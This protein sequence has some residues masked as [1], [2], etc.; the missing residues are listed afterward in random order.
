MDM[1]KS[2][3]G[4][5]SS[6]HSK[7]DGMSCEMIGKSSVHAL[8]QL[9]QAKPGYCRVF[10]FIVLVALVCGCV[11]EVNS[12]FSIFFQYPVLID[13]KVQNRK[14]LEFPAVTLCNLNRIQSYYVREL[15]RL[16]VE[17]E[18]CFLSEH[19][20]CFLSESRNISKVSNT[21]SEL[22][23]RYKTHAKDI[24]S[25]YTKLDNESRKFYG[26]ILLNMVRKCSFNFVTCD[27]KDFAYFYNKQY[28]NCYTFN[29]NTQNGRG[30]RTVKKIGP[31]SG[32]ELE[33]NVELNSYA[34]ITSSTGVKV[35]IHSPQEDPNPLESGINIIS[36]HESHLSMVK[37]SFHRLPPPYRDL[38]RHYP[39]GGQL[40][41]FRD[42]MQRA[43]MQMCGCD[44]PLMPDFQNVV[45]CNL[46]NETQ[47]YCL[48]RVLEAM[49]TDAVVC[50]CPLSCFSTEYDLQVTANVWS[51]TGRTKFSTGR[52]KF[53]M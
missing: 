14:Y 23:K 15:F 42:C 44:D 34:D 40:S 35:I 49:E 33:L 24:L 37:T 39:S 45:H 48:Y 11:F 17:H 51:R 43:N 21:T 30:L 19:K 10:W 22:E 47:M 32:L 1:K 28:G 12:F 9:G 53:R 5:C 20:Y 2:C 7:C 26:H 4:R 46:M 41:C 50:D 18:R 38:C 8:S 36:G 6:G 13:V 27:H 52:P 3:N 16:S 31:E 25:R 29:K